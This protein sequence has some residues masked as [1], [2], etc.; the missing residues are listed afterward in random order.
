MNMTKTNTDINIKT[1]TDIITD[2]LK[3]GLPAMR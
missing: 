2:V 3:N 1:D